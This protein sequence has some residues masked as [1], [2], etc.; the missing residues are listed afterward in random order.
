MGMG[1]VGREAAAASCYFGERRNKQKF[2]N[3]KGVLA[4]GFVSDI[5]SDK[6]IMLE[7]LKKCDILV[8]AT[9]RRDASKYII[10]NDMLEV[11]P[12]HSVILDLTADPYDTTI[13]PP[14]V[15]GIEGIPTGTLDKMVFYKDDPD[16]AKD[17]PDFVNTKVRRTTVSCNAWP[18]IHPRRCMEIYGYQI[19]PFIRL[20]FRK[21][22][23]EL[24]IDS[25]DPIERALY[26]GTYRAYK[27]PPKAMKN[28]LGLARIKKTKL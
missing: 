1:P 18:G 4:H 12:E 21:S 16:F 8:D 5:T 27:E 7:L 3:V 10:T 19:F 20:L 2:P 14:Q 24:S 17:I 26:R 6:E 23:E 22:Y 28:M 11:M 13:D 25:I 9:F 15:K